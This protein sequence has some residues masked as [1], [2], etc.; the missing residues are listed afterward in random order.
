MKKQY[1][2][3][4]CGG[5]S[6]IKDNVSTFVSVLWNLYWKNIQLEQTFLEL[7]YDIFGALDASN[8]YIRCY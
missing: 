2:V 5:M 1:E 6:R 3:G 7:G 8:N 4:Y